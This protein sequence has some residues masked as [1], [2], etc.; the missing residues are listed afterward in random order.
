MK[1]KESKK[2]KKNPWINEFFRFSCHSS[3]SSSYMKNTQ[4]DI[5][6][7]CM[8]RFATSDLTWEEIT[9]KKDLN[10]TRL[11]TS[12]EPVSRKKMSRRFLIRRIK[13]SSEKLFCIAKREKKFSLL[14]ASSTL[15]LHSVLLCLDV[16]LLY[17]SCSGIS[18]ARITI[19]TAKG[20]SGVNGKFVSDKSCT[21]EKR[22]VKTILH[23]KLDIC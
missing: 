1:I 9:A 7:N 15:R 11:W 8:I 4:C 18:T 2:V 17:V 10:S 3:E 12:K 23:V 16:A 14:S 21:T 20:K 13:K 5:M 22:N 19:W 6:W